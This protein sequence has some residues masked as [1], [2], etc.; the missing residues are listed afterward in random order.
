MFFDGICDILA[1]G[2]TGTKVYKLNIFQRIFG[3]LRVILTSEGTQKEQLE[4]ILLFFDF[5]GNRSPNFF[6]GAP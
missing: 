1:Q 4:S 6:G 5:D 3:F 2:K